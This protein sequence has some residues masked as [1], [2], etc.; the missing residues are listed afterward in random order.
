M[1][2]ALCQ[3][4]VASPAD[5]FERSLPILKHRGPGLLLCWGERL[6]AAITELEAVQKH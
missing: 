4:G 2:Q 1:E 3:A 6:P 5:P